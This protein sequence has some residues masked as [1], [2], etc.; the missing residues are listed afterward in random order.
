MRNFVRVHNLGSCAVR[1]VLD[2]PDPDQRAET[3]EKRIADTGMVLDELIAVSEQC[4]LPLSL[5]PVLERCQAKTDA[6]ENELRTLAQGLGAE[7]EATEAPWASFT[8][9][10]PRRETTSKTKRAWTRWASSH[11]AVW[12]AGPRPAV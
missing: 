10:P 4:T 5:A 3:I 11:R 2:R 7:M 1:N 9:N 8:Q 6:L 12:A